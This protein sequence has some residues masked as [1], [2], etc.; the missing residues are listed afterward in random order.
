MLTIEFYDILDCQIVKVYIP[1]FL[2][3][4]KNLLEGEGEK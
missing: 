1:E 2:L 3:R 4:L